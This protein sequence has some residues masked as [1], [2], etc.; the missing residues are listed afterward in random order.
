MLVLDGRL[1]AFG[2]PPVLQCTGP[3]GCDGEPN[4]HWVEQVGPALLYCDCDGMTWSS[5]GDFGG[6]PTRRWRWYGTC[7]APCANIYFDRDRW[8]VPY[9]IGL[10]AD[11]QCV[12]DCT[13]ALLQDDACV[14]AEG[15]TM[16][17]ECCDCAGAMRDDTG[18]CIHGTFGFAI[19][20]FC[21]GG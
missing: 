6:P 10:P 19:P 12:P 11:P 9:A 20:A 3:A 16:P 1:D 17:R 5:D 21:C 4:F 8:V 7:E 2:N 18:H 13:R 15:E 14:D